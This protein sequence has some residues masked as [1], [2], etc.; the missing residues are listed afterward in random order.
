MGRVF[1]PGEL[2][3]W[4]MKTSHTDISNALGKIAEYGGDGPAVDLI[5][6]GRWLAQLSGR[7]ANDQDATELG[8]AFYLSSKVS[9]WK[10]AILAGRQPSDDTLFDI[11]FYAMMARRNRAVGGWPIAPEE[12]QA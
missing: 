1:L 10:A 9:R 7:E 5:E 4:W 2:L 3:E 6:T 11:C 8:I 12:Y